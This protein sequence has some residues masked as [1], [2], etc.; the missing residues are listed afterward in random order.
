MASSPVDIKRP[1]K[2]DE[3]YIMRCAS[4]ILRGRNLSGWHH[5]TISAAK[6]RIY[7]DVMRKLAC[8]NS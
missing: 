1:H 7:E 6:L 5:K 8:E 2:S 4:E 3:A